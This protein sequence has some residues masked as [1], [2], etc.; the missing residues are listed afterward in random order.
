MTPEERADDIVSM[1]AEGILLSVPRDALVA[2][3]AA[4]FRDAE[5]DTIERCAREC[6]STA[7]GH[8]MAR[9]CAAAIRALS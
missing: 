4:A 5:R 8:Y 9:I 3:I 7:G 2:F 1:V 6:D